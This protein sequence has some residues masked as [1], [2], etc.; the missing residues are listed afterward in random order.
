MPK[1]DFQSVDEYIASQP[2]AVQGTLARVRACIRKAVP[3]AEEVISYKMPT[4][5]LNGARFIY[6]AVWKQH[7][8]IYAATEQVVAAFRDE[9]APYDID[10]GT[11]RFP[12]SESV[13]VQLIGRIAKFRAKEVAGREKAKQD[14]SLVVSTKPSEPRP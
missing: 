5:T 13:P 8:A 1:N 7:Y 11:I 9:L 4:Y 10:K 14:R 2:E 6:F 3:E 12:L